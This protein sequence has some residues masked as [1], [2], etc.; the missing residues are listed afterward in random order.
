MEEIIVLVQ[1][2]YGLLG[3]FLV[4]PLVAVIVVWRQNV[5][6]QDKVLKAH[7]D[8]TDAHKQRVKDAQEINV[9][10]IDVLKEQTGLNI[11]TNLALERIGDALNEVH[12]LMNQQQTQRRP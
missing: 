2:S 7:E 3:V 12:H 9:K 1:K 5:K 11:E 6:L 8:T 10:L 4:L